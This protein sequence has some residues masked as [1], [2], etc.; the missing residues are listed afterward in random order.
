MS[1][2]TTVGIAVLDVVM[3]VDHLPT[4]PGKYRATSTREIGGGVA[5]N[6]AV[7]VAALGCDARFVGCVG[8]DP[9]GQRI[10]DG[11]EASRVDA[12]RVRRVP[13]AASPLSFVLVDSSG[14]RLIV[15]H[16]DP[17]LFEVGSPPSGDE[18]A[19][20]DAVL[21]DMRWPKGAIAALSAARLIGIPAIV[22]CDHDP[23]HNDGISILAAAS[24][25]V[26]ALP[27]LTE[28][29]GADNPLE[30]LRGVRSHTDA[31][32]AATA[33]ADGVYW[34]DDNG[35]RHMPAFQVDVVDTLG[36]GDV[37]HGAF[38]VALVEGKPTEDAL[39]FASAASA[40]KCTR[41]GGRA[42]TPNRAE[43]ETFLK[44]HESWN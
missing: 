42:G 13:R 6:A 24:H 17:L 40:I 37:F 28:F 22:D 35:L 43:V 18:L 29:T 44:E 23:T 10:V 21:V 7:A 4:E 3:T 16:S 15:N 12:R 25:I 39:R 2:I 33:G 9:T 38:A 36:A 31:W 34:L 8:G 14:E 1:A 27:T 26:F 19:G 41:S 20:S 30:A 11:M 32:V 5:A